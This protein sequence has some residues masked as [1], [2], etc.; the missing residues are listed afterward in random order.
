VLLLEPPPHLDLLALFPM[1]F[2]AVVVVVVVIYSSVVS[3]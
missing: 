3:A 2:V 1:I